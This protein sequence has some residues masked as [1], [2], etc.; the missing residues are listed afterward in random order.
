MRYRPP[1]ITLQKRPSIP[2]NN[3]AKIARPVKAHGLARRFG[4]VTP[5]HGG[6]LDADRSPATFA[7]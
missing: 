7:E 1:P 5:V 2:S 3:G 4:A 6:K